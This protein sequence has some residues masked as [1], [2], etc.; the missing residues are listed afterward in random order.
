[1]RLWSLSP[2][3]LDRQGLLALWREALLAKKVLAGQ[4]K[5]YTKHPQLE[6][7]SVSGKPSSYIN[8]YLLAVY[9]EA[10]R[11]GYH[12]DKGK[13]GKGKIEKK[14]P[15]TCGQSEY[16]LAHLKKKLQKRDKNKWREISAVKK[17]ILNTIFRLTP[18]PAAAWEK[19]R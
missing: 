16:E 17:P 11:R 9:Q 18:G 5:G 1:M 3:Y 7:F 19:I 4:T 13:I 10:L 12:F 2:R 6:R 14:I 8:A 15:V